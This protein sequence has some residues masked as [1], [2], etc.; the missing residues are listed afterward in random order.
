[1]S[2]VSRKLDRVAVS[3][4]DANLVANAG[5]ILVGTLVSR[6]ELEALI[7]ATVRLV[8]KVGGAL[9]GRKVLTIRSWPA[10]RISITPMCCARATPL[11]CCRIG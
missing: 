11:E 10:V 3:F 9:P 4:D 5:L 1:M 7:N 6:L 2:R 8:G